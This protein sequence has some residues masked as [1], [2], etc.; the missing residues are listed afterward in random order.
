MMDTMEIVY[1]I[2]LAFKALCI[3]VSPTDELTPLFIRAPM[4]ELVFRYRYN[5]CCKVNRLEASCIRIRES[6]KEFQ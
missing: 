2:T 6:V 1:L 3:K 4:L 5:L